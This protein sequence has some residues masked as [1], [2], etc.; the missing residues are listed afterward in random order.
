MNATQLLK[1]IVERAVQEERIPLPAIW[2][3]SVERLCFRVVDRLIGAEHA[4]ALSRAADGHEEFLWRMDQARAIADRV[5]AREERSR[6]ALRVAE[7]MHESFMRGWDAIRKQIS[8]RPAP[9]AERELAARLDAIA[10]SL[11]YAAT[12]AEAAAKHRLLELVAELGGVSLE[13]AEPAP[14]EGG[15]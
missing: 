6:F 1:A 4:V 2:R 5:Q 11:S 10:R 13:A 3:E 15:A 9:L 7:L 12:E 14:A 8:L